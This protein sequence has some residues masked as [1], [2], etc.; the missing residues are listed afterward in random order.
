MARKKI[1]VQLEVLIDMDM[2]LM[3]EKGIRG[4]IWYAIH[5]NVTKI[6]CGW[7]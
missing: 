2:L 4:R 7:F 5:R 3:L 1:K 6:T